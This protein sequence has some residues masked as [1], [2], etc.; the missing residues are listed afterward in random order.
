[1]Q[2]PN[3]KKITVFALSMMTVAAV[4]SLRGLPMM[5]KKDFP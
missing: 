5:A 4:F 3:A 1:M 2:K